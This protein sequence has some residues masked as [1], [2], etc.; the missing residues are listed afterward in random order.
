[1]HN[2]SSNPDIT[3]S[4]FDSLLYKNEYLKNAKCYM[5]SSSIYILSGKIFRKKKPFSPDLYQITQLTM[6]RKENNCSLEF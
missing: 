5:E 4:Q 2:G 1:M 6:L 3:L